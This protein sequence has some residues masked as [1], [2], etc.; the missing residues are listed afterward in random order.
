MLDFSKGCL[1][2]FLHLAEKRRA[3]LFKGNMP[4]STC[5]LLLEVA[6]ADG[7]MTEKEC[8]R[9][10]SDLKEQFGLGAV[11]ANKLIALAGKSRAEARDLR[12]VTLY[13][14]RSLSEAQKAV[15]AQ[16]LW[17]VAHSDGC[18]AREEDYVVRRICSLVQLDPSPT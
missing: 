1:G 7:R 18:L 2:L 9:I 8:Y 15:L 4:L 10:V 14:S 11:P 6:Y 3:P 5:A 17:N 13:I 16:M 12:D